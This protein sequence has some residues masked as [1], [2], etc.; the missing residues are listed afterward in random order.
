[1]IYDLQNYANNL[2]EQSI[3]NLKFF[4]IKERYQ[5]IDKL[6]DY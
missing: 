6:L 4:N 1:M 3:K 5:L 2:I